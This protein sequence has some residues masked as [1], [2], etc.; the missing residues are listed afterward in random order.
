M[1]LDREKF[2]FEKE[3]FKTES[4]IKREALKRKPTST[5]K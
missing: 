5:K 4:S 2:S 3:K 1:R